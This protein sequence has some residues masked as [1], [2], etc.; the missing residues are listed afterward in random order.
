MSA[1]VVILRLTYGE[2]LDALGMPEGVE[3]HSV[4]PQTPADVIDGNV[5]LIVRHNDLPL[6]A[7]G[8][9][10]PLV[11]LADVGRYLEMVT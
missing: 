2:L 1:G 5:R 9:A 3:V 6:H 11:S 4:M 7:D 8:A 10:L